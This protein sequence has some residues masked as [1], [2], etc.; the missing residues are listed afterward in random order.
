METKEIKLT[1]VCD[2]Q[3][4]TQ[5]PK[6][7][8]ID[9]QRD[10]Y[11]RM[12]QI[13]DFTQG[14]TE[15]VGFVKDTKKLNKCNADDILIGRYG[16]SVGKILTGL[17][18]AYNVAIIKTI[19]DETKLL[20]KYLYY[21]LTGTSFQDFISR[22]GARA[23][24]AGFNKD[25]LSYFKLHLPSLEN[26]E[27]IAIILSKTE[28]L[29]KQRKV[30]IDLLNDLLKFT[31]T[32]LFGDPVN[33]EK[34]WETKTIEALVKKEK[35]SIKRGPF[36]GA[37]KKEIFVPSG[38]LVYEQY[39]A[40][41]NDFSFERYYID[42]KKFQELKAFEVKA[43]DIIISCSGIYLG[44]LAVL[45]KNAKK[46][47]INQALL[48]ISLDNKIM[49]NEFF[50]FL[51]AHNSFRREFFGDNRGSGIPNF[52]PIEEFKKFRFIYPPTE[53]QTQ[54][55]QIVKKIDD[56]KIEY[57]NSRVELENLFATLGQ[58]AFRGELNII[59]KIVIE[60]SKKI[61]PKI[62]AEVLAIDKI[63]NELSDSH[64]SIPDSG[65]PKE[66]DNKLKKLDDELMLRDEIPFWDEYVKYRLIKEKQTAPFTFDK[67]WKE[68]TAFPFESVPDYEEFSELL[69]SWLNEENPF[70]KQ[71]YNETTK[72]IELVLN[73]TTTS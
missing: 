30:S 56:I 69:F 73:E 4:G 38:Y 42:E 3:G 12:L 7:E 36:G 17:E 39:H 21:V 54:F 41:N 59:E 34:S 16:A 31:F 44:K 71:Q 23:A 25:D 6:E 58:K 63:N 28:E 72:Q 37:L 2:F 32:K 24:Q 33:N 51:F 45:P 62:S 10:G 11:V 27:R 22:I 50:V 61:Q 20:K 29:I 53:L 60:G 48:K 64:K 1:D 19:P 35:Y 46:G 5:P 65:A 26:Q 14:K 68:I 52:P 47:I 67:L 70:I 15:F 66:I 40:L 55:T 43:G 18:G 13:R 9:E 8:W 57:E 49:S